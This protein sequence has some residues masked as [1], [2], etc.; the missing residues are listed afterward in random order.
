MS[1]SARVLAFARMCLYRVHMYYRRRDLIFS[2]LEIL[3]FFVTGY[4][5]KDM[6]PLTGMYPF[7]IWSQ[8]V[9]ET[10]SLKPGCVGA[11]SD[12]AS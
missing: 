6:T 5:F 2:G 8:S 11:S 9:D 12:T 10:K 1:E 3:N 4:V 7:H